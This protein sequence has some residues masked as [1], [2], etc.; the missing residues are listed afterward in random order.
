MQGLDLKKG[1]SNCVKKELC[2]T[3]NSARDH[4][5]KVRF[6]EYKSNLM[7]AV[8]MSFFCD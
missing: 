7:E 1:S 2:G 4:G 3:F 5:L 8:V 6:A